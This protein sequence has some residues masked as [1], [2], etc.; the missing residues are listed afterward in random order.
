MDGPARV[1]LSGDLEGEYV[2]LA[3]R[4][5][6]VLRIAPVP[7]A[8]APVVTSLTKTCPACPS[9]WEGTLDDGRVLYA[10]YRWGG[11]SVGLGEG[12]DEAVHNGRTE[13]S[14]FNEQLGDGLDGFMSFEELRAQ[15]SGLLDFPGDLVVEG[16]EDWGEPFGSANDDEANDGEGV[17]TEGRD[18]G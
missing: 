15:L 6:N 10:R 2:V 3:H 7:A 11:L 16:Q 4:V 8:G 14:L 17:A 5:G 12:I 1:T 13:E 18:S 9:Q